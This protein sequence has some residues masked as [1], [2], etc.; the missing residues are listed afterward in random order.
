MVE[1]GKP[2]SMG[3]V[4]LCAWLMRYAFRRRGAFLVVLGTMLLGIGMD[5][6]RPWPMAILVDHVLKRQPIPENLERLL[7]F[8]PGSDRLE[9]LL[10][11]SV[12]GT[13]ILFLLG[14][15]LAVA[16][17]YAAIGFGQS[18]VYDLA[19]DLFAHLQRLSLGFHSRRRLGDSIR[20]VTKDSGCVSTIIKDALLPVLSALCTLGALFGVMLR[21]SPGLTLVAVGVVPLMIL[22]FLRYARP[23]LQLSY[24]QNDAEGRLYDVV[25]E[26]LSAIPAIQAFGQEEQA[27]RRF[28]E[29][30]ETNMAAVLSLTNVQLKFKILV[31]VA[32]ALGT[33]GILWLGSR[34]A[35][36][37]QVSVG[38]IL[39][40]L[41]YL[42]SLYG[43]LNALMFSSSAVQSAA[44]SARRVREIFDTEHEVKDRPG[45][46]ALGNAQGYV[47]FDNVT[48]GYETGRPFLR[49]VSFE[50]RP[51]ETIAVVGPTGAGKSTLLSLIPRLYD[52]WEGRLT[53]DSHDSRDVQL[54]SLR[55]NVSLVLQ[56]AF[57]F[58]ISIADNI[59]YGRP[60]A[61][62]EEIE[63]AARV[64]N[65]HASIEK[66]PSG[67]ETVVGERGATLSGGERQRLSIA[68][69]LLKDAPIL[70]LDEPTSA[71]DAETEAMLLEA[72]ERLMK[73]RTTFIIAHRLS[74]IRRAN[75]ILVLQKG[76]IVESGTHEELLA[77]GKVYADLH[78]I[79]FG[80]T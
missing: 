17:S 15:T 80:G 51:G 16:N 37:G 2:S 44:A 49:N 50:V 30:V 48:F 66:L 41:S 22:A 75:R 5:L 26:T 56:E 54:Q 79:Q 46:I 12:S 24:A 60:H 34:Q 55:R 9:G 3:V 64:A 67:Y 32:T 33:A 27:D 70:I 8:L 77:L 19:A 42:A 63:R 21:I 10:A 18:M 62:R 72:L 71:L 59:A 36:A 23:L 11:W 29:D 4:S 61:S 65:I 53:I 68:R 31:G 40:F 20:R 13:V 1:A 7:T 28:E 57:L 76:R 45:A 39:V 69:A 25:E 52:P 14:W 43:P 6:L 47:R 35:L 38:Q 73:G 74:T 78:A 58:P